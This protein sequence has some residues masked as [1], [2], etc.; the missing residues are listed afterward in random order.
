MKYENESLKKYLWKGLDLDRYEVLQIIPINAKNAVIIMHCKNP[1]PVPYCAEYG[2]SG[3]YFTS[4]DDLTA[5]VK[6]RF[7]RHISIA[8]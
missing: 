3:K 1:D 5:Y 8:A 4:P 7:H 6:R 2:G